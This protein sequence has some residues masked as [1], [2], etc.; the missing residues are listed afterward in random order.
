MAMA[1]VH[2]TNLGDTIDLYSGASNSADTI[3]GIGGDDWIFAGGGDDI[4]KG[5]GGADDINGGMGI[6]TVGYTISDEGVFVSLMSHSG[7]GGEAEGDT[8]VNVE[9]V[10]GSRFGDHLRGDN[11]ANELRGMDGDDMLK[12]YGGDDRLFGGDDH[13][14][15]Y[16]MDG[17]DLLDGGFGA[18]TMGGGTGDDTYF[19]DSVGDVVREFGGHGFDTVRTSMSWAL[20]EG[21]D[22]ELLMTVNEHRTT[23][24]DL[25]GNS[26]GNVIR[27][28]QGANVIGGGAGNDELIGLGGRD[29]FLFNTP[30]DADTNVDVIVDFA[31]GYDT[32]LLDPETFWGPTDDSGPRVQYVLDLVIGTAAQDAHDHLIYDSST[33]ALFWDSDGVGGAA[34]IQFAELSP[35]LPLTSSDF[36]I[37]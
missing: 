31:V 15:L 10:A 22:V 27:G 29:T 19:V 36:S 33:G 17:A 3:F 12:G 11:G 13:D 35:G 26:S 7:S 28:N 2:G 9:N 25:M 32:I 20:T 8:L 1:I 24:L 37:A 6:D 34:A 18:D 14:T 16:G 30:L 4:I 21:A 5:G 23:A